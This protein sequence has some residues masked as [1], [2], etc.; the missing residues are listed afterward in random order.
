MVTKTSPCGHEE[1]CG[2]TKDR[3]SMYEQMVGRRRETMLAH[4]EKLQ[5][6]A[7]NASEMKRRESLLTR[8]HR[9]ARQV[10]NEMAFV[11]KWR[12]E[13]PEFSRA[14]ERGLLHGLSMQE[15]ERCLERAKYDA[16]A[17]G[18]LRHIDG[19]WPVD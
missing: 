5:A 1:E 2:H 3:L 17:T 10:H 9:I 7:G 12:R 14:A 18:A 15:I 16:A 4:A 13:A 11:S 19:M 6:E 8:S